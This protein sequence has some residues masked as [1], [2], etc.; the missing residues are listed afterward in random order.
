MKKEINYKFLLLLTGIGFF[1]YFWSLRGSFVM[2]DD[3]VIVHNSITRHLN[4]KSLFDYDRSRFITN[5]SFSI[6]YLLS[7]LSPLTYR[8]VNVLIHIVNSFLV[9]LLSK[10]LLNFV[11]RKDS[12]QKQKWFAAAVSILFL[13]HPL[14]TQAVNYIV[15]RST[16]LCAFFYLA[17]LIAYIKVRHQFSLR[18]LGIFIVCVAAALYSKQTSVTLPCA[19]VLIDIFFIKGNKKVFYALMCALLPVMIFQVNF[20]FYILQAVVYAEHADSYLAPV[21]CL[22]TQI[23]VLATYL[24]LFLVP[25]GQNFDYDFQVSNSFLDWNVLLPF[26]LILALLTSA[27][28][29]LKKSKNILFGILFFFLVLIPESSVISLP[30][31]IFEH[32]TYLGVFGLAFAFI[33]AFVNLIRNIRVQIIGLAVIAFI[34]CGFTLHRNWIWGDSSRLMED[35]VRKSPKKPR[36]LNNLGVIYLQSNQL[37]RALYKFEAALAVNPRYVEALQNL[38]ETYWLKGEREQAKQYAEHAIKL[39]PRFASPHITLGHLYFASKDYERAE[40]EYLE[41]IKKNSNLVSAY[42]GLVNIYIEK[43]DISRAFQMAERAKVVDS[44]SAV[45]HYLLGNLSFQIADF[46]RAIQHYEN[47]IWRNPKLFEAYNNLAN[48]YFRLGNRSRAREYFEK[49]IKLNPD[50][51]AA[52]FNLA[53][54]YHELGQREKGRQFLDQAYHYAKQ[55]QNVELIQKIEKFYNTEQEGDHNVL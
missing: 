22:L 6:N 41:A 48:V 17:A 5:L 26:F 47:A 1:L 51:D 42:N 19:F 38:A 54:I 14:Q 27:T 3:H 16:L 18:A 36:A 15:Q 40:K 2:D 4:L 11:R 10:H 52:Y 44:S 39:E 33:A 49:I 35:T 21:N 25:V 28:V 55:N 37:D 8:L 50:F 24:K 43:S 46:R 34:F 31:V 30:D 13:I 45:T 9:F 53:N 29:L 7:G 32:R 20:H 23:K 12:A